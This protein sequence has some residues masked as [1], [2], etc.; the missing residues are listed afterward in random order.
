MVVTE[1]RRAV[2][3][4]VENGT[5]NR[6]FLKYHSEILWIS[7]HIP[8][9]AGPSHDSQTWTATMSD[10]AAA[11]AAASTPQIQGVAG[12]PKL[13]TLEKARM[14]QMLDEPE[15]QQELARL[16][17]GNASALQPIIGILKAVTS[18]TDINSDPQMIE[19][20]KNHQVRSCAPPPIGMQRRL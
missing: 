3:L 11:A 4:T 20:L 15:V 19:L 18:S 12:R 5:L 6:T 14:K 8:W 9:W 16:V 17:G 7:P 2:H 1:H 13:P 10:P